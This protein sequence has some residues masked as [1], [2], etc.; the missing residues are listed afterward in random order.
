M[1]TKKPSRLKRLAIVALALA[2]IGV[3]FDYGFIS[4]AA[5]DQIEAFQNQKDPAAV[6]VAQSTPQTS[7]RP[8]PETAPENQESESKTEEKKEA[9]S[10]KKKPLK[11]F[12]PSEKIE[13]EQAVDFPYDI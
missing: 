8:T 13:A 1:K 10:I 11:D 2:G 9:T 12:K 6:V 3:V 4:A 7:T 5:V